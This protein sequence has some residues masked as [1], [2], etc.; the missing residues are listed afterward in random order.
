MTARDEALRALENLLVDLASAGRADDTDYIDAS[1]YIRSAQR[2]AK[3]LAAL[4]S[5]PASE[6]Q[7]ASEWREDAEALVDTIVR[8]CADRNGELADLQRGV[9]HVLS[10]IRCV[11]AAPA[12]APPPD[13]APSGV[14]CINCGAR[15]QGGYESGR[16]GHPDQGAVGPFCAEC[17]QKLEETLVPAPPPDRELLEKIEAW[18]LDEGIIDGDGVRTKKPG[19]GPCCTCGTCGFHYDDCRCDLNRRNQSWAALRAGAAGEAREGDVRDGWL[20]T[21]LDEKE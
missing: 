14:T 13:R 21:K 7:E 18:L 8:E 9:E 11:L 19:H 2:H 10:L 12:P 1:H 4:L 15:G 16:E 3:E 6:A 5:A 20:Y 17:W